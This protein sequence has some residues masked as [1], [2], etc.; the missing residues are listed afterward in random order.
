MS[1]GR[2]VEGAESAPPEG[3]HQTRATGDDTN[4]DP[5]QWLREIR[6][7]LEPAANLADT[8]GAGAGSWLA[9]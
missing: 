8:M 3:P 5:N 2:L 6:L 7:P 9:T 1:R 4:H